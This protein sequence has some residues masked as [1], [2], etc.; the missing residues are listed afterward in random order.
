MCVLMLNYRGMYRVGRV[1]TS[2]NVC[3]DWNLSHDLS[4]HSGHTHTQL[5]GHGVC[6]QVSA[7]G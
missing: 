6:E 3:H 5:Q 2:T 7:N 4:H 1:C